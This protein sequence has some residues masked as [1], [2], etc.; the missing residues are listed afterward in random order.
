MQ[1]AVLTVLT[2]LWNMTASVEYSALTKY[3]AKS[4]MSGALDG[5]PFNL[6]V[7]ENSLQ[8]W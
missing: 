3:M 1:K 8:S 6:S 7:V 5:S 4:Y 2:E